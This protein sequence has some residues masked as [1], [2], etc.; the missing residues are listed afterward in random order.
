MRVRRIA[1]CVAALFAAA[2]LTA[3]PAPGQIVELGIVRPGTTHRQSVAVA[4]RCESTKMVTISHNVPHLTVPSNLTLPP[5]VSTIELVLAVPA[6]ATGMISGT[7]TIAFPGDATCEPRTATL[8]VA[9]HAQAGAA[10]A[11]A[12]HPE[13]ESW[14]DDATGAFHEGRDL[15]DN[16]HGKA[17]RGEPGAKEQAQEALEQLEKAETALMAGEAAGE[18]GQATASILRSYIQTSITRARKVLDADDPRDE[19]PPVIYGEELDGAVEAYE[20][21]FA[22]TQGVWQDDDD[23]EDFPD[24]QLTRLSPAH[25][26]AELKMIAGRPA[27]L[28]GTR[29]DRN[30]IY[31]RGTTTGTVGVPVKARFT[32]QQA[33]GE[34]RLH[35]TGITGF[36]ALDGPSGPS[37][38]FDVKV[39]A[40]NGIPQNSGFEHFEPGPY[41]IVA[42]LFRADTDT[43]TGIKVTVD[44]EAVETTTPKVLFVPVILQPLNAELVQILEATTRNLA[45]YS[46]VDVPNMFPVRPNSLRTTARTVEDLQAL[47]RRVAVR[48]AELEVEDVE[49]AQRDVMAATVAE[50]FGTISAL[51]GYGRIFVLMVN[52]D[53]DLTYRG[54]AAGGPKDVAAY[55]M[56]RK[57]MAGR[58]NIDTMT[59]AHELIHTLPFPWADEAMMALFGRNWHNQTDAI[60]NGIDVVQ[61]KGL[62]RDK[63]R[64][65]MGPAGG[66]PWITQG[67]YWHLIDLLRAPVDPE[68]LLVSGLLA[69]VSGGYRATL[70]PGYQMLGEADLAAGA[71]TA[72]QFA[73]VLRDTSGAVIA[74]YP[75]DPVWNQPDLPEPR[76]VVSFSHRV[77]DVPGLTAVEVQAP[78]GAVLASRRLSAGPPELRIVSPASGAAASLVD[79]RLRIAWDASDPDGDDLRFNVLY[80]ADNGRR[81]DVVSCEQT[82]TS[83]DLPLRGRPSQAR[84]KVVATDGMRSVEREIAFSVR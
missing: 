34:R 54:T 24:K 41:R 55:A 39:L 48:A 23:F 63:A 7:I 75:F 3:Q 14:Y 62:R 37:T 74:Q 49:R 44:G 61:G 27:M 22:P 17:N 6:G 42:E 5:G 36:V 28:V 80:S 9:A 82:E 47:S 56:S 16:A 59:V 10:Q 45:M 76:S 50:R 21:G 77:P 35:D 31:F 30:N 72:S 60:A 46:K 52:E 8:P 26:K 81:W 2:Q 40:A 69:R 1:V 73:I 65:V 83:F 84:I 79:G 51:G 70:S 29:E 57:V 25:L 13:S 15:A 38:P 4:N 58:W 12:T 19:P 18:I 20:G 67:T 71:P 11:P 66:V 53:F 43:P 33:G 32:L 64:G 78:G 68:L